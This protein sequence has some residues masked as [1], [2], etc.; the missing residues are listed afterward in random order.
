MYHKKCAY[1]R[2]FSRKAV[3]NLSRA[4]TGITV[5][6][7]I[8]EARLRCVLLWSSRKSRIRLYSCTNHHRH[9]LGF[10]LMTPI[11]II[12]TVWYHIWVGRKTRPHCA[13]KGAD[14]NEPKLI[15]QWF[16]ESFSFDIPQRVKRAFGAG[17]SSTKS[18]NEISGTSSRF[19]RCDVSFILWY[20]QVRQSAK[21][22][23]AT[24]KR[25]H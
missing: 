5:A 18:K 13:R 3:N 15:R 11:D 2:D 22:P 24:L 7:A 23:G 17:N 9:S 10:Y 16:G 21:I 6:V 8:E 14:I 4:I 25:L 12:V 20:N 1:S 19:L